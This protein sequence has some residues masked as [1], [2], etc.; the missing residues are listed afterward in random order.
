MKGRP[1]GPRP[2]SI[3]A[4][5]AHRELDHTAAAAA[6]V[7]ARPK[8]ADSRLPRSARGAAEN[9]TP[10][11]GPHSTRGPFAFPESDRTPA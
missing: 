6:R 8:T 3:A 2:F 10:L 9:T 11:K 5:T 7:R 4:G 1:A